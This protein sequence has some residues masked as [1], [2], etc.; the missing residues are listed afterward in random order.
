MYRYTAEI[1]RWIDG[2]TVVLLI[3]LG[4]R[5]FHK[6]HIRL[7]D[8]DAPEVRGD[9]K[10]MGKEVKA[11]CDLAFPEGGKVELHSTGRDKYGRYIGDLHFITTPGHK[12]YV[13]YSIRAKIERVRND[14]K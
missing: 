6:A 1:I 9:E 12:I 14:Q 11:F 5:I 2:D 4:Y 13:N 10:V 7:L 8:V 3:D